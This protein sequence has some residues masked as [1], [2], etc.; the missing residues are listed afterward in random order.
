ML[1]FYIFPPGTNGLIFED[2][3]KVDLFLR[4]FNYVPV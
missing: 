4:K 3:K 1:I 2:I